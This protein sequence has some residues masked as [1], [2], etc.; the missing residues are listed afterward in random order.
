[1]TFGGV[2]YNRTIEKVT[3]SMFLCNSHADACDIM[4]AM[5]SFRAFGKIAQSYIVCTGTHPL[6]AH[7]NVAAG[8]D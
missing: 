8:F 6:E 2:R 4:S 5:S 3:V 1:M 7:I